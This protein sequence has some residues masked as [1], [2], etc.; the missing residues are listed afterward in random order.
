MAKRNNREPI[1]L[2]CTESGRINYTYTK[3]K[4]KHPELI[5]IRK[6]CPFLRKHTVHREVK[7]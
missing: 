1:L 5:E 3:D 4:K 6:Y 2:K 7:K